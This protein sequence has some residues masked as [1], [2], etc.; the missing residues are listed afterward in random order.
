[1]TNQNQNQDPLSG[2]SLNTLSGSGSYAIAIRDARNPIREMGNRETRNR[3]LR[4]CTSHNQNQTNRSQ[5]IELH[6]SIMRASG[7]YKIEHTSNRRKKRYPLLRNK[8][9]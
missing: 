6:V 7:I 8:C 9:I 2:S 3:E 1:M 5:T 4:Y